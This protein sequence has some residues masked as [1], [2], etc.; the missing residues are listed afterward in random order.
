MEYDWPTK[1]FSD[2]DKDHDLFQLFGR[3]YYLT[4]RAR[5]R[6]LQRYHLTP[7]QV[8]VLFFV[9]IM[10]D[11]ATPAEISRVVLRKPHTVSSLVDRMVKRGLLIK[12]EHAKYRNR[13][14][15]QITEKGE[16]YYQLSAKRG[17][18][19]RILS[20]LDEEDR[21]VFRQLLEKISEKAADELGLTRVDLPPSD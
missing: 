4:K 7:E 6:E 5:E 13:L 9:R 20:T 10:K 11:R 19:R 17:P 14:R 12:R 2:G 18:I 1:Y 15:L 8:Q 3:C 16:E 21:K